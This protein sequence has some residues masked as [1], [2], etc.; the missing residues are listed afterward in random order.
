MDVIKYEL[1]G[2]NWLGFKEAIYYFEEIKPNQCK[3]TRI[4]TYTSVLRPRFYWKPL[5]ELGIQQE[6]EYVFNNLAK[7]LKEQN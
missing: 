6:H 5:E 2:R 7:D 4:T 3:L 1:V